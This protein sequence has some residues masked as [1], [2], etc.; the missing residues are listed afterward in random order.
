MELSKGSGKV[1]VVTQKKDKKVAVVV[2]TGV[3]MIQR[4][5]I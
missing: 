5:E 2:D 1:N 3:E 4:K